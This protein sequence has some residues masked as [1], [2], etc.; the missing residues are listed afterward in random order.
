MS[1]SGREKKKPT[2][3]HQVIEVIFEETGLISL[4]TVAVFSVTDEVERNRLPTGLEHAATIILVFPV[5]STF[6]G[7]N[8]EKTDEV[9]S[10]VY[11]YHIHPRQDVGVGTFRGEQR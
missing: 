7:I 8:T 4:G 10:G 9:R 1:D 6:W 5:V 3:D 11:V 2:I